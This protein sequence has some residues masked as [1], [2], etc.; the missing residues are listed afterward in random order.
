LSGVLAIGP[1][2]KIALRIAQ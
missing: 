2:L 1:M